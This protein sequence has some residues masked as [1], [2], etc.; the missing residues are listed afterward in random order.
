RLLSGLHDRR[1]G[2]GAP[3]WTPAACA[4]A[5]AGR[6]RVRLLPVGRHRC[7]QG[8]GV[9]ERR[10]A[11][12]R[13]AVVRVAGA[14]QAKGPVHDLKR[15]DVAQ[16]TD[17]S[18]RALVGPLR[19]WLVTGAFR[20]ALLARGFARLDGRLG[21]A[22][23]RLRQRGRA[24][25]VGESGYFDLEFFLATGDAQLL[26]NAHVVGW[27]ARR[28]ADRHARAF[29]RLLRQR[30]GLEE[31]RGPQPGIDAGYFTIHHAGTASGKRGYS[32]RHSGESRD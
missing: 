7:R 18:A 19:R 15:V 24:T 2:A 25:L 22:I 13:G 14:D 12:A 11:G 26:A 10:A 23:K 21:F 6:R 20:A 8:G 31:A 3:Q 4:R 28:I 9:L 17:Q 1:W 32:F 29:N 16:R 30:A 5:A 27:L